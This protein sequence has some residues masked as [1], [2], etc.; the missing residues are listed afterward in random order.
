M[1]LLQALWPFRTVADIGEP[2]SAPTQSQT[3]IDG[4]P[5]GTDA[6]AA[7]TGTV[8]G[9][10]GGRPVLPGHIVWNPRT[11]AC[12]WEYPEE[13]AL[14]TLV[15]SEN[16]EP[17][18]PGDAEED[19]EQLHSA[20]I[21]WG[22]AKQ[23]LL[24]PELVELYKIMCHRLGCTPGPWIKVGAA[25]RRIT[26]S[27]KTYRAIKWTDG[28]T[29]R[30]RVYQIPAELAVQDTVVTPYRPAALAEARSAA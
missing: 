26:K 17:W 14:V 21:A 23:E 22:Y 20:L 8:T 30:V 28:I 27:R 18:F 6:G 5:R 19:A 2:G 12:E 15:P 4:A 13:A 1:N 11:Q 16:Q 10:I 29:R 3:A 7:G 24:Y 25:L 9:G